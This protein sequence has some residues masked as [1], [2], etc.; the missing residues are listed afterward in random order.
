[1]KVSNSMNCLGF[2]VGAFLFFCAENL[3]AQTCSAANSTDF[4]ACLALGAPRTINVTGNGAVS[5]NITG[6]SLAGF[7]IDANNANLTLSITSA[8]DP[9]V[10]TS[11][12]FAIGGSGNITFMSNSGSKT[13]TKNG[14][15]SIDFLNTRLAI[16][17]NN[18]LF[19]AIV[20]TGLTG[21][22]ILPVTLSS[23]DAQNL[24]T[25]IVLQWSTSS[26]LN[27]AKFE[28]QHST[29][30]ELFGTIMELAGA[31]TTLEKQSYQF[32]HHTPSAGINYYRL[33]QVDFDG[34]FEYSKIVAINAVGNND[35]VT[36][37]NPAK[38]KVYVQYDRSKGPG[39]VY[40]LDALGRRIGATING[41]TGFYEINLPNDLPFGAYWLKIERS[42]KVQTVAVIKE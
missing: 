24:G 16:A 38:D 12:S 18:S 8:P 19:K 10:S 20:A 1:M 41:N 13:F 40:L 29:E 9:A 37:P 32:T 39:K 34:T 17:A 33:K 11:T 21:T 25:S 26:E 27:N 7:T 28:L 15:E 36:Y 23:F 42:G 31:G 4:L 5:V 3:K 35:I 22:S 14:S 30:G 2:A 6:L